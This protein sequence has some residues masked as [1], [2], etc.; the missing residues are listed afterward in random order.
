M[1]ALLPA[2]VVI[3]LAGLGTLGDY[4]IKSAGEGSRYISY[5]PFFV[6]MSVYALSAVGWFFVMK[7]IKLSSL[8]VIYSVSTAIILAFIGALVFKEE[9]NSFALLGI[10]LG[11]VS[12]FLLARFG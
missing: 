6:G 4:F 12:L 3:L 11:V 7:H 8:G 2:I 5:T 9:I 1:S 10:L